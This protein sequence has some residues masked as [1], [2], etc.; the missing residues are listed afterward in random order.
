M[1][2][3]LKYYVKLIR[4]AEPRSPIYYEILRD[5]IECYNA[6]H[7]T[8]QEID[9]L[10]SHAFFNFACKRLYNKNIRSRKKN[11]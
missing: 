3:T 10:F 2:P 4:K 6:R 9:I 7:M 5:A 1:S 8:I 11:A